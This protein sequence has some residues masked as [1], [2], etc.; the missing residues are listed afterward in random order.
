[1]RLASPTG[2]RTRSDTHIYERHLFHDL[3]EFLRLLRLSQ[4]VLGDFLLELA[5]IVGSHLETSWFPLSTT[6][7][8]MASPRSR[9]AHLEPIT[10]Q[11]CCTKIEAKM[12]TIPKTES[13][14]GHFNATENAKNPG[15]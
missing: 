3:L 15:G 5:R 12:K 13:S 10:T 9:G 4:L 6:Y 7:V 14:S 1:M 8:G 11:Q 2:T